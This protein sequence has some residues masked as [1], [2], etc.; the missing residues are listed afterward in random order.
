CYWLCTGEVGTCPV[1]RAAEGWSLSEGSEQSRVSP[2][3]E[4]RL[5][6]SGHLILEEFSPAPSPSL[7]S[8]C[9]THPPWTW[10]GCWSEQS[11]LLCRDAAAALPQSL[12]GAQPSP[13][14]PGPARPAGT[15]GTAARAPHCAAGERGAAQEARPAQARSPC[16][17]TGPDSISQ[18]PWRPGGVGHGVTSAAAALT[19]LCGVGGGRDDEAPASCCVCPGVCGSLRG[20]RQAPGLQIPVKQVRSGGQ[21]LDFAVQHLQRWL[22]VGFTS[23]PGQGGILA[24]RDFDRR[25]SPHFLDWAAFGVMTLPSIGIPLL[26]WY[27]SKRKYDTPKTKKN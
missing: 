15:A 20:W 8:H 26:L 18:G 7:L 23:A 24:Q 12:T 1:P 27:S 11:N 13:A 6:R 14:Q 16:V 21:G 19:R 5:W 9:F 25:F 3:Q 22:Q 4:G 2:V 10:T 17:R